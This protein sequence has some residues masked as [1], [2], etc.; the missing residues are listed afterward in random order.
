MVLLLPAAPTDA[1]APA[2][3]LSM[4]PHPPSLPH[5]SHT[6]P[7]SRPSLARPSQDGATGLIVAAQ[8]GHTAVVRLLLEHKAEVNAIDKVPYG[9]WAGTGKGGWAGTGKGPG[10]PLVLGFVS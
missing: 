10:D 2:A 8:N 1:V 3:S 9:G 7:L 6:R 4:T 5:L